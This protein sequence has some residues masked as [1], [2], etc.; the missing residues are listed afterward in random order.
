MYDGVDAVKYVL[1]HNV[2][3]AFVES[4]VYDGHQ[5]VIW[6]FSL[7][8]SDKSDREIWMYDTFA[9]LV[10]P[11]KYD[12]TVAGATL[13]TMSAEEVAQEWKRN[14][15]GDAIGGSSWCMCPL[16]NV[17]ANI[18][19]TGYPPTLLRFNVGDVRHTLAEPLQPNA[20]P[21]KIAI[22]RLDTDWYEST[23]AEL[24]ALYPRLVSGGILILDD[25]HHWDGQRRAADEYFDKMGIDKSSLVRIDAKTAA[26]I[27]P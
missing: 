17:R 10:E 22:L 11:S 25:Y 16:D 13:Y 26:M 6:C 24:S 27:K 1:E 2:P 21:D 9:G 19:A 12:R 20:A 15:T 8:M 14:A 18:T 23:C 7:M 4:G 3:G 5:Q